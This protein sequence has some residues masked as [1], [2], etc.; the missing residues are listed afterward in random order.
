MEFLHQARL[1]DLDS[2]TSPESSEKLTT[3]LWRRYGAQAIGLLESIREDPRQ[4]EILIR[5]TEYIRCE[6]HQAARREM[7][8]KLEDFLRRRSKIALVAGK[9]DIRNS[10]GLMEA[11][12]ILFGDQ[13]EE[14][15]DEYFRDQKASELELQET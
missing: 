1:M 7:I 8:V 13:A 6:I 5:G 14:K 3:R 11:C 2:Y 9:D 4:A 15:F 12:E 10:P